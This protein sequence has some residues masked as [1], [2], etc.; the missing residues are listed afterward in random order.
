MYDFSREKGIETK[1][2]NRF[3]YSDANIEW[4]DVI[5]T[6]GGDGTFLM[7]ASKIHSQNKPLIGI[8]SDPSR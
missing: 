8:N 2:V 3:D 1:V 4:A 6:T 5:L 7:A